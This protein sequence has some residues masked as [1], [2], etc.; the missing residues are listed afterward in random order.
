MKNAIAYA[1]A[2]KVAIIKKTLIVVG[3]V[4]AIALIGY[5]A[6]HNEDLSIE[7]NDLPEGGFEVVPA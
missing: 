7:I 4:A 1:K 6:T 5:V 3:T 2:N